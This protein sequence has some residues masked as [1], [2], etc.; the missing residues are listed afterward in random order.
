[1]LG[2]AGQEAPSWSLATH[3]APCQAD[4]GEKN[5]FNS[6]LFPLPSKERITI[7]FMP[8]KCSLNV[9]LNV[10]YLFI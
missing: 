5:Y 9:Y 4:E 2:C 1:M 10:M 7:A 3:C 6:F 8:Q